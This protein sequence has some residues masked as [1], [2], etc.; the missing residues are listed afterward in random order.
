MRTSGTTHWARA[1]RRLGPGA[2]ARMPRTGRNEACPCGSGRKYKYCHGAPAGAS[3]EFPATDRRAV[4]AA[5]SNLARMMRDQGFASSNNVQS[6][7]DAHI[8]LLN[9]GDI[10]APT[11]PVEAAQSMMYE[12]W[13]ATGKERIRLAREALAISADCADAYVL[14]AEDGAATPAEEKATRLKPS[15][16]PASLDGGNVHAKVVKTSQ[17]RSQFRT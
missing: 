15:Q 11:S 5:T 7:L 12:A 9:S 1:H 17:N 3:P 16:S 14:L 13:D 2:M 4:E 10:P 6:F 8:H